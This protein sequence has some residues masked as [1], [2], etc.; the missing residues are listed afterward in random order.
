[1]IK[2]LDTYNN[3]IYIVGMHV[4]TNKSAPKHSKKIWLIR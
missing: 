1:M 2:S 3:K 4:A